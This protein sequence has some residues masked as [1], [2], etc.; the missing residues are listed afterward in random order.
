MEKSNQWK[1]AICDDEAY[2][3]EVISEKCRQAMSELEKDAEIICFLEGNA[4]LET[5]EA[6][7]L[8]FLDIEMNGKTGFE[9]AKRL[10]KKMP[11]VLIIFIT[12]HDEWVQE[13][14]K[15][16]AFRYL[17]KDVNEEDIKDV[18]AEAID[19]I[20]LENTIFISD[21]EEKKY[22]KLSEI[23]YIEALGEAIAIYTEEEYITYQETLKWISEKLD[24]RF[25]QCHRNYIINFRKVESYGKGKVILKNGKAIPISRRREKEFEQDYFEYIMKYSR[26]V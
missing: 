1:I 16:K 23:Y 21:K 8:V 7:D 19:E 15:V 12:S 17:Y 26:Y 10:K 20:T 14:F 18:I 11:K 2:Y 6:F 25:F 9:V 5:S 3:R 24:E 22:L 4:L 13:A